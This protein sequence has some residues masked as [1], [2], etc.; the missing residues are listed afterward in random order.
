MGCPG[1]VSLKLWSVRG[2][3]VRTVLEN[4]LFTE[5]LHQSVQWDG[6]NG[7][8]NVVVNG[9]YLAEIS[10]TYGDGTGEQHLRKVAV[11]R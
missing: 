8:G 5:G 4:K 9:T 1:R 6:R 3:E 10:I 2:G 11:V 7:Q